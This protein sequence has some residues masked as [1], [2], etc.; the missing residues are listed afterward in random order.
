MSKAWRSK[1]WNT[2]NGKGTRHVFADT[3]VFNL[4]LFVFVLCFQAPLW[5]YGTRWYATFLPSSSV[6]SPPWRFLLSIVLSGSSPSLDC[7]DECWLLVLIAILEKAREN[8]AGFVTMMKKALAALSGT[9]AWNSDVSLTHR[10]TRWLFALYWALIFFYAM[11]WVL[12]SLLIGVL[13]MLFFGTLYTSL[14]RNCHSESLLLMLYWLFSNYH[15]SKTC[16]FR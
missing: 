4:Y 2:G 11:L 3:F 10:I 6:L 15:N 14:L 1:L 13:V 7:P 8:L 5:S 9:D 16:D 12:A